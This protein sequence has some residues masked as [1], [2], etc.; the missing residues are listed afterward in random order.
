MFIFDP[1]VAAQRGQTCGELALNID[2]APTFLQL[3]GLP[4]PPDMQGQSLLPLLA[5]PKKPFRESFF[6]E[7]PTAKGGALPAPRA[8]V[9]ASGNTPCMW[10]RL[11]PGGAYDVSRDPLEMK[12]LL[13]DPAS[14]SAWRSCAGSTSFFRPRS[15]NKGE[16]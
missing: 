12:N 1:R 11:R 14:Q 13:S 10:T 4:V 16:R 9:R 8:S 7:H 2:L 15:N 6:Y 5:E 3:A